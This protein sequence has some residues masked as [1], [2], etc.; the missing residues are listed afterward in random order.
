MEIGINTFGLSKLMGEDF[1]GT[2]E[3]MKD[4]GITAIEPCVFYAK[5]VGWLGKLIKSGVN[6]SQMGGGCLF[7]ED[8]ERKIKIIK[9][10]GFKI[11]SLHLMIFTKNSL[12]KQF[13]TA[14]K[15]AREN[16]ISYIV[17]SY[18]MKSIKKM[19]KRIAALKKATEEAKKYGVQILYHNH[20]E[21][22]IMENGDCVLDYIL[23]EI[24]DIKIQIDLGWVKFAGVDCV[25]AMQKYRDR[26]DILH[27]KDVIEGANEKNK[28]HCFTAIGEGSIPL[29]AI[30]KEALNL[31]LDE[32]PYV[33]DQD[34]S[35]G[36]MLQ[37]ILNG[38]Q[39]IQAG[40]RA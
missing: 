21:E 6:K 34:A 9:E 25:T 8:V 16:E 28:R 12:E 10:K 1:E 14:L 29:E 37:D 38:V 13:K 30:M 20:S 39:N 24:P 36:D 4:C 2:L 11:R 32:V 7:D 5:Q 35:E 15:C 27:F 33:I 26:I 22:L 17:V 18:N 40:K 31:N 3:N 23:R 19:K